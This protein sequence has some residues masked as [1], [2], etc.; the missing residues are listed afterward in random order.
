MTATDEQARRR[1]REDLETTFVVEAAAGTGKT[2]VLVDRVVALVCSGRG[3]LA[4]I[5][6]V[7]FTEK[8]AGEMK[9]RLRAALEEAR[10]RQGTPEEVRAR[11]DASLEELEA[12]RIGTIHS[13]C[14]DL[15]RERPVEAGVDPLFQVAPQDEA[16]K[17]LDQ[18]FTTWFEDA[19][20]APPEG[21][22]RALR[23]RPVRRDG[24]TPRKLLRDAAL[25]LV[26]RRDFDAPW[27][28]DAAFARAEEIDAAVEQLRD[29]GALA[30]RARRPGKL[31]DAL[32]EV[33]RFIEDLD[34]RERV[35]ARDHDGLE[36]AL[37]DLS[38]GRFW[39]WNG[40]GEDYG[41]GL[42]RARVLQLRDDARAMLDRLVERCDAD[43]ASRLREELWP[44][45]QRYE[46]QKSAAGR[47]DFTDLLIKTRDMV[48]D[49]RP[50]RAALQQRF[51]HLFV[52]E[53]Q[54]TDPLQ[55]ELLLLLSADDPDASTLE[56][57]RPVPG[58]LFIVGDPKQS[59]YSFRRADVALYQRIKAQLAEHGGAELLYL[60]RSFRALPPIQHAINAA[61]APAMG[62]GSP[63]QARYVPLEEGRAMVEAAQPAII[64]LPVPRPYGDFG[65]VVDFRIEESFPD[66]VAAFVEFLV[67]RSGWTVAEPERGGARVPIQPRHICILFR[68]FQSY[69]D[70][71]TKGYAAALEVRRIPHVLVGGRSFHA[72]EEVLALRNALTAVEWP[73]DELSVFA[74][75]RGPLFAL[76]DDQ[77]LAY[78]GAVG[79]MHPLRPPPEGERSAP[80]AEV[81]RALEV[82]RELHYRRNRR[83]I[84]GT[85]SRLLDAIRAHAGLAFW[86]GG[87]QALANVL[88]L[89]ELAR[90]FE[91]RGATSFRAFVDL[92]W[93]EAEDGEAEEARV[94]EEG[95]EGVR[96]MTV[97]RAKGLE[98]PVVI[99][100]DPTA[101]AVNA[102]PSR[103]VDTSRRLWAESLA[104]CVPQDLLD[105]RPEALERDHEES[106]RLAYVA[107]TRARD[108]LVVPGVG[109][110][111]RPGWL[112][113]L[114]PVITPRAGT[115]RT[116]APAPGC[117]PFGKETVVDRPEQTRLNLETA[118]SPGLHLPEAGEHPVSWWDPHALALGKETD[119]TLRRQEILSE[120]PAGEVSRKSAEEHAAWER[121]RTDR[122]AAA[123]M[124][125]LEISAIREV[126]GAAV[127]E[128]LFPVEKSSARRGGRPGGRRF[129]ALVHGILSRAPLDAG[130]AALEPLARFYAR[131]YGNPDGEQRAAV[132]AALAALEHPVMAR[133]RAAAELRRE[134]PVALR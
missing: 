44:V 83:P 5:I 29:V 57:V 111:P 40:Y 20:R 119:V 25:K 84:A 125:L 59:I 109:D 37:R 127:P 90:R 69:G 28:R 26:E 112:E 53:F 124:P 113:V 103:H 22:R 129:G 24:P 95:T 88:H 114:N 85:V 75:L 39:R 10:L 110:G 92:L 55:A 96:L 18:A 48:R 6:A 116:P 42:S 13:L 82:L 79:R 89:S 66:A 104:G 1:I 76:G 21:T 51:T 64:V 49:Q 41:D 86:S 14:A 8:A 35:A 122:I 91:S 134:C 68:R 130:A 23:R 19:L 15:L 99:L 108:L 126:P 12:A 54:D 31:K 78:R 3:R 106:L 27:R 38:R 97:H 120:D 93:D 7:T 105:H 115:H 128:R 30:A 77:L 60:S 80:V 72:R 81:Q 11:L 133:A 67:R 74:T 17:L 9:L 58:K 43:V 98:F 87:E 36:A 50:V 56:K 63:T 132:E 117:P 2:T 101:K 33:Q 46:A 34:H 16:Q 65:T 100:A 52:D 62:E 102:Q 73:D 61:F 4:Q 118:V 32:H 47:L 121:A 131:L 94:V 107:A 45:V 70:D 71:L 123:A